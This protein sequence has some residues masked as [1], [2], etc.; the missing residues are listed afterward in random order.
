MSG[1]VLGGNEH[2]AREQTGFGL[3]SLPDSSP[4]VSRPWPRRA[5]P[6][7]A[8]GPRVGGDARRTA[9][10]SVAVGPHGAVRAA[11]LAIGIA[12]TS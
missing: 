8:P 2:A 7:L 6:C 4:C 11:A 5:R 1:P 12:A 10:Q 3:S 9:A